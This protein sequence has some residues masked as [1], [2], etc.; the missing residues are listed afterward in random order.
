MICADFDGD[1][2]IDIVQTLYGEARSVRLWRN[3]LNDLNAISVDIVGPGKNTQ[4]LGARM[5]VTQGGVTQMRE[6]KIGSNFAAHDP[7]RQIFGL[8]DAVQADSITVTF[9]DGTEVVQNDVAAG[10]R[11]TITYPN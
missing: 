10:S 3:T 8:G 4:G 5:T 2:D 1:L 6:V 7:T 9:P 11:L